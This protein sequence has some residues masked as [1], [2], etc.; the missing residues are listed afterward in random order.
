MEKSTRMF[1]EGWARLPSTPTKNE[2]NA[3]PEFEDF[4]L[5]ENYLPSVF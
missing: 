3:I 5:K 2:D 1:V 4:G